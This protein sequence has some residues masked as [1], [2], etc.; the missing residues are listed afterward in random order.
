MEPIS[1]ILLSAAG[2]ILKGAAH[3]K[4]ADKAKEQ[5]L[6]S[7]WKW[8][9]PKFIKDVPQIEEKPDDPETE[10]KTYDHLLELVK[11][12]HFFQELLQ[13]LATLQHAGIRE[14]N[15]ARKDIERVKRIRIGDKDYNPDE[16]YTRKNIVE[17][18]VRD[19][20]EFILGDGN[21]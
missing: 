8:I 15:I 21:V 14:K 11:D 13:Q 7:F 19:A 4:T 5:V 9:K 17:G 2:Y 16:Q 12:E 20:D 1:T 10:K 18:H 6:G 3:S